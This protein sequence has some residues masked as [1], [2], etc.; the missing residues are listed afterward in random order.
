MK[1]WILL[2]A[3][4]YVVTVSTWEAYGVNGPIT[5]TD[6]RVGTMY[7]SGTQEECEDLAE[8]L[9]MA[10]E[11]R[12]NPPPGRVITLTDEKRCKIQKDCEWTGSHCL[13]T[14]W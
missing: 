13:C 12:E 6:R 9:N 7:C 2:F 10:N 11:R 1:K 3:L 4:P 14:S 5:M 8:A